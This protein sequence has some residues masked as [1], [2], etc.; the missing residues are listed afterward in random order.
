MLVA[1]LLGLACAFFFN[2]SQV[3]ANEIGCTNYNSTPSF[4]GWGSNCTQAIADLHAQ[5]DSYVSDTCIGSICGPT[6]Y[7]ITITCHPEGQLFCVRGY[8]RSRCHTGY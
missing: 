8:G 2:Q 1:F 5:I 4:M 3:T 7:Y 6:S